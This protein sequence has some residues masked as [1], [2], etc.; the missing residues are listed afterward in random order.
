MKLNEVD[1][2][3]LRAPAIAAAVAALLLAASLHFTS[4]WLAGAERE[5]RQARAELDRAARQYRDAS[6]DQAVYQRYAS[7]FTRR[8]ENGW[9][10]REQR[11]SWIEALQTINADLHL[12]TLRYDIAQQESVTPGGIRMPARMDLR[13]TRMRLDI[14]ALHEGDI[15]E[16]LAR[17][18]EQGAGLMAVNGCSLERVGDGPDI[19]A[20]PR[21]ANID[22]RCDLDWYTLRLE[23]E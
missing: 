2:R 5:Y 8:G 23:P 6:D 20:S 7:R 16:V 15:L 17:L 12:P 10:G 4:Q 1:L 21:R 18:R 14:G 13:R 19:R 3:A 9:I 22:A 11:L